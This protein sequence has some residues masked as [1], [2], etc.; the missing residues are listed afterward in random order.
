MIGKKFYVIILIALLIIKK[1]NANDKN[2]VPNKNDQKEKDSNPKTNEKDLSLIPTDSKNVPAKKEMAKFQIPYLNEKTSKIEL[3]KLYILQNFGIF[4]ISLNPIDDY[5]IFEIRGIDLIKIEIFNQSEK[6]IQ[7]AKIDILSPGEI[8][9]IPISLQELEKSFGGK[10][11]ISSSQKNILLKNVFVT[12]KKKKEIKINFFEILAIYPIFSNSL[13][14]RLNSPKLENIDKIQF[15][16]N[17]NL[18]HQKLNGDESIA[19]LINKGETYPSE[20]NYQMAGVQGKSNLIKTISSNSENFCLE[21]ICEYSVNLL[22]RNIGLVYFFPIL[23]DE[24]KELFLKRN[25]HIFEELEVGQQISFVL[26]MPQDKELVDWMFSIEPNEGNPDF[27]L[28]PDFKPAKLEDYWYKGTADGIEQVVVTETERNFK[29][30]EFKKIFITFNNPEKYNSS[31]LFKVNFFPKDMMKFIG[32]EIV[33]SGELIKGEIIN[34]NLLLKPKVYSETFNVK[35][36]LKSF[37]GNADIYLKEC[38]INYENCTITMDDINNSLM[39]EKYN[40]YNN[41]IFKFS[42]NNPKNDENF[43]LDTINLNFNCLLDEDEVQFKNNYLISKSCLF[44]IG[45]Y[46]P[47]NTDEK[48]SQNKKDNQ[49]AF[50]RLNLKG[51]DLI[52]NLPL[53]KSASIKVF[54]NTK[55]NLKTILTDIEIDKFKLIVFKV[56]CLSGDSDIYF[57]KTNTDPNKD[58]FDRILEIKSDKGPI[59]KTKLYNVNIVLDHLLNDSIFY[60]IEAKEFSVL[61]IYVDV[62]ESIEKELAE[63]LQ[64]NKVQNRILS[65]DRFFKIQDDFIYYKNFNFQFDDT[66]ID[67]NFL[68]ISIN[69]NIPGIIIN[70]QKNR[71]E[72]D[73]SIKCD[74]ASNTEI[75]TIIL[76]NEFKKTDNLAISIQK[77]VISEKIFTQFP[78]EFAIT[79]NTEKETGTIDLLRPGQMFIKKL[80][81]K[82]TIRHVINL[83]D[84]KNKG[85]IV[86]Y[87]TSNFIKAE[88]SSSV[89][90]EKIIAVLTPNNFSYIIN[91]VELFINDNFVNKPQNPEDLTNEK[92]LENSVLKKLKKNTENSNL[93]IDLII[94]ISNTSENAVRFILAYTYDEIPMSLKE[95]YTLGIPSNLNLYLTTETSPDLPLSFSFSNNGFQSKVYSQVFDRENFKGKTLSKMLNEKNYDHQTKME[96]KGTIF[97]QQQTLKDYKPPVMLFLITPKNAEINKNILITKEKMTLISIHSKVKNLE[98]FSLFRSEISK[99][100]FVYFNVLSDNI[101]D[102]SIL[103][104]VISGETDLYINPGIY[105]LTTTEHYWKKKSTYKGDEITIKR[106]DL[107]FEK[108]TNGYKTEAFTVGVYAREFSDFSILYAPNFENLIKLNNQELVDL[109]LNRNR[110]YLFDYYNFGTDFKTV[111]YCE[112]NDVEVKIISFDENSGE[113]LIDIILNQD[114]VLE[115][116]V[117]K[118][119]DLPKEIV[120]DKNGKGHF[121]IMLKSENKNAR[122]N[123]LVYNDK[124]PIEVYSEKRFTF[125]QKENESKTFK[126]KLDGNYEEVDIDV[127]SNFGEINFSVSENPEIFENFEKLLGE[128]QKYSNYNLKTK[129]NSENLKIFNNIYVQVNSYKFSEYSILIK[130]K[131]KFKRL[132][133]F[134]TETIYTSKTKDTYL[135]YSIPK[136]NYQE[137]TKLTFNIYK[138]QTFLEKPDLLF[139]SDLKN[140]S[141]SKNSEFISMPILEFK[142]KKFG[143]FEN[144]KISVQIA[145]GYYIL[146]FPKSGEEAAVRITVNLN[147]IQNL[148]MNESLFE[149]SLSEKLN[150]R[151][152]IPQKG[153]L[154]VFV[155]SCRNVSVGDVEISS[156]FDRDLKIEDFVK[157]YS[158]VS[159][160][161][162]RET[163]KEV[164]YD[165]KM[166]KIVLEN[167]GL[168]KF[169]T[170]F[171]PGPDDQSEFYR[172]FLETQFRANNEDLF[173]KDYVILNDK[174]IEFDFLEKFNK[175]KFAF[176]YEFSDP[177]FIDQLYVDYPKLTSVYLDYNFIITENP[178]FEEN[179]QKCGIISLKKF[180]NYEISIRKM[181]P[182]KDLKDKKNELKTKFLIDT[183]KLESLTKPS[184][185]I[186]CLLQIFFIEDPQKDFLVNLNEKYTLLPY[187]L[188]TLPNK[189]NKT[190]KT[191]LYFLLA[192]SL[193]IFTILGICIYFV[194]R[195]S[196][197]EF[198]MVRKERVGDVSSDAIDKSRANL[199]SMDLSRSL[200]RSG[201]G[202]NPG[203]G[204]I[205]KD[206][207]QDEGKDCEKG[208]FKG[209]E[210]DGGLDSGKGSFKELENYSGKG[211]FKDLENNGGENFENDKEDV[212]IEIKFDDS[213]VTGEDIEIRDDSGKKD[214]IVKIGGGDNDSDETNEIVNT[215]DDS[216]ETDEV[217]KIGSDESVEKKKS[218]KSDS[219]DKSKED[220]VEI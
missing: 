55:L 181:I 74:F 1:I 32:E 85:F 190:A 206:F 147:S 175:E 148:G 170:K 169:Q 130:P 137:I 39:P 146:K 95:G 48:D 65:R 204:F 109:S 155:N 11:K 52:T 194:K 167:S 104:N 180:S 4:E 18:T 76:K 150:Y 49:S 87:S 77:K 135:Y 197:D 171:V 40:F 66:N 192:G 142:T 124:I 41:R 203:R 160:D 110:E 22:F 100:D 143:E 189:T 118:N 75:L 6:L 212:E 161:K 174:N 13:K 191:T 178:D 70:V 69:T 152:Y 51:Q 187:F 186:F 93:N 149:E 138:I 151:L 56:I 215:G 16:L 68:E 20:E 81:P 195:N 94:K 199:V 96:I 185:K 172:F 115:S 14:V 46:C 24:K 128:N 67:D 193:V 98:P 71:K 157:S 83:T 58:D 213:V 8:F 82:K 29:K 205:G 113:D 15:I 129:E 144:L 5:L 54:R 33:E 162:V 158:F 153:V 88:I 173:F 179:F 188:I 165:L 140:L 141:L 50:F 119:R 72:F 35:L 216:F 123:L 99:N 196:K 211:S 92:K 103:M 111:M 126:V 34:Y 90:P 210:D 125:A 121:I 166:K 198:V 78:I 27:Y 62:V 154:S 42:R 101:S 145:K 60:S 208:S 139:L 112:F 64:L 116:F 12:L 120:F 37:E 43:K 133:A 73:P 200:D 2:P 3:D 7:T 184:F 114:N 102:F 47:E 53:R 57:S 79:L 168:L 21:E 91:D 122:I 176:E 89:Y 132:L 182:I 97:Y 61:E 202:I 156:D 134:E 218:K 136:T 10:I 209:F 105:N 107:N 44:V 108:N 23:S 17:P 26:N 38:D 183:K 31:F 127:H 80:K 164:F 207:G 63:N 36:L 59:L 131:E 45:I 30:W 177:K 201:E 86:L 84:M 106:K 217:V 19:M 163:K 219:S 220:F 25:L 9:L 28:N 214:E 159:L 117:L